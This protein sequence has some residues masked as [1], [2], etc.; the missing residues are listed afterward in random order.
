MLGNHYLW[1]RF[2]QI[3]HQL[4][5]WRKLYDENDHRRD[6]GFS[7]LY[8]AAISVL[9]PPQS[10]AACSVVWMACWLAWGGGMFI[11]LLIFLSRHRHFQS[12]RSMDKK[13][14]TSVKFALPVWSSLVV[15]CLAP[16]FFTLLLENDWS[17]YLLA[18]VC[19]I[20]AQIIAR[21]IIKF[22]NTAVLFGKLYC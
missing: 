19:L 13:A 1:L 21:M 22:P 9:S 8:A 11:G 3:K 2:I 7:L 5:A 6:G 4:F 12:T 14:L 15:V 17:G 18:I 16:V 10:P 20:A